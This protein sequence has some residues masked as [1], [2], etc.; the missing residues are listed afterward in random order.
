MKS[1][2]LKKI[3][4]S[5]F[6]V[7]L[8]LTSIIGTITV[9]F[10]VCE[11]RY[12]PSRKSDAR[13]VPVAEVDLAPHL[14]P[15]TMFGPKRG[16]QLHDVN[17]PAMKGDTSAAP[18]SLNSHGFRYDE[19]NIQKEEGTKRIFVVGGSVVFYGHTNETTISGYLEALLQKKYAPA[20]VQVINT[21]IT[22]IISDQE[23]ILIVETLIDFNPDAVIVFDGYN[24][25][26]IPAS[27][28]QRLGYPFKFKELELAWYDSKALLQRLLALPFLSHLR[29]GSHFLRR[30]SPQ[31]WSYVSYLRDVKAE[32]IRQ[33]MPAP[34]A[35]A[36]AAHWLKN[37]RKMALFLQAQQV[38]GLFALQPFN[39]IDNTFN[40][41]YDCMEAGIDALREE[42]AT[43]EPPI[44]FQ[45][46]RHV[47]KEKMHLFYDFVHTYDEGNAHYANLLHND[48]PTLK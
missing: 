44:V 14:Q 4:F 45:S 17:M 21:G 37:W 28:E 16:V 10:L 29:A 18:V 47:M 5:L 11:W 32:E 6:F 26:L 39:Q 23:L 7:Y 20:Q 38:A 33:N 13:S 9:V 19:L 15:Y 40:E 36:V 41:Q 2:R 12:T 1:T 31:R 34:S 25:C 35:E 22:G 43:S 27:F 24:D 48:L 3:F 8:L 46:Y 42:F 30:F